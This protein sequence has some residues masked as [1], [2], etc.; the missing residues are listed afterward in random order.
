MITET[1]KKHDVIAIAG[2]RNEGKSMTALAT[3]THLKAQ[4]N[5]DIALLGVEASL[6]NKCEELGFIWL[7]SKMDILDL[8]LRDTIIYIDEFAILFDTQSRSKQIGKLEK[9]FDRINHNNCKVLLSTAR[10]GFFNKY[11]CARVTAFMVKRIEFDSLTN[12]TWLKERVMAITDNTSQYRLDCDK[13]NYY[14]V[15]NGELTKKCISPYIEEFDS[16]KDNKP[17]LSSCRKYSEKRERKGE[18]K[19]EQ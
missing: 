1:F 8:Q 3:L 2:N 18:I 14:L 9:F 7:T 11:M 13:S 6:Q 5:V 19:G 16:K 15:A 10:E 4:Y 12:G 17:L